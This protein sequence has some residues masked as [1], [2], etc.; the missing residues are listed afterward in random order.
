MTED[1]IAWK[2][3][4]RIFV[5]RSDESGNQTEWRDLFRTAGAEVMTEGYN[6]LIGQVPAD[7]GL[8]FAALQRWIFQNYKES[9]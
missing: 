6:A 1:W 4:R 9:A 7:R 8:G 2:R 3:S 5:A